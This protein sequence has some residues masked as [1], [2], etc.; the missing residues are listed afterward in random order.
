[1]Y[2]SA[3]IPAYNEEGW[4]GKTVQVLN[5]LPEINEIIVVDDGSHDKTALEAWNA[6]ATVCRFSYNR[7]KSQALREGVALARGD[8][9]AFVDADLGESAI[10]FRQ[11]LNY[12][13][14]DEADM[15]IA[16]I[17]S[18]QKGGFGLVKALAYWGIRYYTGEKMICPL[19]GQ[20]V[21]KRFLWESL[22]FSGEGFAA[23]VALTIESLKKGFKV[24]EVPLEINHRFWGKNYRAF[25]HK[26]EQF[27]DILKFFLQKLWD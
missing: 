1:M 3:I 18:S 12:V 24:K 5:E 17:K 14:S 6:G 11:L 8:I 10:K 25:L 7:G 20:R 22:N 26:G 19:S 27:Y 9:L 15:V 2:I 16:S 4:V 13:I 21:L 23:E